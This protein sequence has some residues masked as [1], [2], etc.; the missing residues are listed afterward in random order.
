MCCEI[1]FCHG[2]LIDCHVL[3]RN[4]MQFQQDAFKRLLEDLRDKLNDICDVRNCFGE[5][6]VSRDECSTH[7]F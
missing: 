5:I 2:C 6:E 3:L 1:D 4:C 7:D